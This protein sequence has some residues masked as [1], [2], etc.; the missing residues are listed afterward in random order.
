MDGQANHRLQLFVPAGPDLVKENQ[1]L[2]TQPFAL[3]AGQKMTLEQQVL[4]RPSGT[5]LDAKIFVTV[6]AKTS[7]VPDTSA[8]HAAGA[9]AQGH[10]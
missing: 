7:Q 4:L 9:S 8:A 5:V 10:K 2:A 3:A 1:T 6:V